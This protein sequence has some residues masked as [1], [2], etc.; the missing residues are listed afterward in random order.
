[1]MKMLIQLDE[2][3]LDTNIVKGQGLQPEGYKLLKNSFK[4]LG[5]NHRYDLKNIVKE[6]I[7]LGTICYGR[8]LCSGN[9]KNARKIILANYIRAYYN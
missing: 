7:F 6:T 4:E 8:Y 5:V 1:M 2:F 9:P 3:D